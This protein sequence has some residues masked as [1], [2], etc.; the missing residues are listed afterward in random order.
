MASL[1]AQVSVGLTLIAEPSASFTVP[2]TVAVSPGVTNTS[3][4]GGESVIDAA[5]WATV[6]DA[7]PLAGPDVAVI[8]AVPFATEVTR[9]ASETVAIVVSDVAHETVASLIS[10]AFAS[11]TV[12]VS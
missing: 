8:V 4:S 5:T 6:T 7:V 2:V 10:L 3:E 9:P 1:D 12:A 11:L